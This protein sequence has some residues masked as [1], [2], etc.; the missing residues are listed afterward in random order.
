MEAVRISETSAYSNQT[1]RR[2][3]PEGCHFHA[4]R[5]ENP[6][7]HK[8]SVVRKVNVIYLRYQSYACY[9]SNLF[10]PL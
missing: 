5:R 9:K 6:K 7:S 2:Y 4:R 10:Q 1:T 3:I 8:I